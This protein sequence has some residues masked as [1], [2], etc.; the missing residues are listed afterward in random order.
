MRRVTCRDPQPLSPSPHDDSRID[1]RDALCGKHGKWVIASS[2]PGPAFL[3]HDR[4]A[5]A[6]RYSLCAVLLSS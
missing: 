4:T 1:V 2:D 6:I 3:S 5:A